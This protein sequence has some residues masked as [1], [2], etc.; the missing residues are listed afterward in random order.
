M[1]DDSPLLTVVVP[2]YNEQDNVAPLGEEITAAFR[3]VSYSWEAMWVDDG[4]QDATLE[5]LRA[6]P[7]PHRY[8]ALRTNSGQSAALYAGFREARGTWIGTLDGDGQND[9]ADL[10]RQLRHALETHSD[11]VNGIRTNR[12]DSWI[13]RVSS[14]LANSY[15]RRRL[16]DGVTDVGCSTRVVKRSLVQELPFF[17]GMHRYLPALVA[18]QG[19]KLDEI[20]VNH[21]PRQSGTSKYGVQNR[22]WVGLR[23]VRGVQ[24]L[25]QRQRRWEI[26]ERSDHPPRDSTSES[27]TIRDASA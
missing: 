16:N 26:C 7:A 9:P 23:D 12:R 20:D 13:R 27:S 1:E 22:L 3:S 4:S 25:L 18:A 10:P 8:L 19:A 11:M 2:V 15:R 6:L 24:W 17:N 5:G 14:Q 21:R